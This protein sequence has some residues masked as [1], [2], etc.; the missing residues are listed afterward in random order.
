[1]TEKASKTV[2]LGDDAVLHIRPASTFVK[3]AMRF[4]CKV[5]VT[6]DG[7]RVNGKSVMEL[8]T[9]AAGSGET[10][11]LEA[12]GPDADMAINQLAALVERGFR[13]D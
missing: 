7:Q 9:L 13:A 6:R 2:H 5:F 1:M 10:L 3:E 11:I 4:D 8:L 12:E